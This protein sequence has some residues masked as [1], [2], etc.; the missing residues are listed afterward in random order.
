MK[1]MGVPLD[2]APDEPPILADESSFDKPN[3]RVLKLVDEVL[4][5]NVLEVNMFFKTIQVNTHTKN[6]ILLIDI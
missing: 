6:S 2:A 3:E 4:D 5:L 1:E